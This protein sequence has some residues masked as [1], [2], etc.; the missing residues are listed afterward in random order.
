[1]TT[2]ILTS[3]FKRNYNLDVN[4]S[5]SLSM[6]AEYLIV[7]HY[8]DSSECFIIGAVSSNG[9]LN[10]FIDAMKHYSTCKN[11]VRMNVNGVYYCVNSM[12]SGRKL[13]V[14]TPCL[15]AGDYSVGDSSSITM[16]VNKVD[17]AFGEIDAFDWTESDTDK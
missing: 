11:N 9:A 14:S 12:V 4:G 15:C 7:A 13:V 6:D 10:V 8:S 5:Y 2:K 3:E 16:P 17:W 1:M